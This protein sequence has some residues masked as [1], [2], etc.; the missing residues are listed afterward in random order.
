VTPESELAIHLDGLGALRQITRL[1]TDTAPCVLTMFEDDSLLAAMRAGARGYL[2][3]G[4]E[5]E[6]IVRAVHAGDGAFGPGVATRILRQLTE[7]A[8]TARALPQLTPRGYE[9]L[10]LLAGGHPTAVIAGRLSMQ[11]K[12]S[13][14][15]SRP[16]S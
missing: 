7:P 15:L 16:C 12:R 5:Q 10:D 13:A 8:T 3:K 11:R 2:L 6:D 1:A 4:A 9:V 14:T